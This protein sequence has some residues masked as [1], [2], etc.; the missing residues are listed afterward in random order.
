MLT[1][2]CRFKMR[3]IVR[4][5]DEA[6]LREYFTTAIRSTNYGGSLSIKFETTRDRLTIQ[7]DNML[8]RWRTT[9]WIRVTF[10]C[11]LLFLISW[12]VLYFSTKRYHCIDSV[13]RTTDILGENARYTNDEVGEMW[14]ETIRWAAMNG[15]RSGIVSV[16]EREMVRQ[17]GLGR[18]NRRR[19]VR[20]GGLSRGLNTGSFLGTALGL[21]DVA[22]QLVDDNPVWG[23]D[24][25]A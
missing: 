19:Q 11:T 9:K 22:R 20:M 18:M 3:K 15:R 14:F 5:H 25:R 7:P 23:Q 21:T 10:Y 16:N 12:P 6:L 8:S 1:R 4:G 24:E 17:Q 13:W 2:F